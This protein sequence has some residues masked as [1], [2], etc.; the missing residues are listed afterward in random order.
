MI[1]EVFGDPIHPFE[2]VTLRSMCCH[3][4][5]PCI[6]L[7]GEAFLPPTLLSSPLSAPF[8]SHDVFA[9][10]AVLY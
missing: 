10:S 5:L 7:H 3:K 6:L 8:F 9:G 4:C 2:S 1:A